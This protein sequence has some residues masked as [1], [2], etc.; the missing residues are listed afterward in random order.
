MQPYML[1]FLPALMEAESRP[2]PLTAPGVPVALSSCSSYADPVLA[3]VLD[4]VLQSLNLPSLFSVHVLLK[5]NLISAKHSPLACTE[6]AFLLAVARWFVDQGAKVS[7]G[8]SPAFG[9]AASVLRLLGIDKNL[10]RL[11]VATKEFRQGRSCPLPTGG[12]ALLAEDAL[13]ADLLVNLPRVKAHAQC[14]LTLAV[15]NFFGCVLGLRKAWWHML[16]GGPQGKFHQRLV[17]L[18]LLLPQSISLADG[19]VAMHQTGPINGT[20][21]P[22]AVVAAAHNPVALDRALHALLSLAP[23]RSPVMQA[24]I[25]AGMSGSCLATLSFPLAAPEALQVHDFKVPDALNPIRF[26]LVHFLQSSVRRLFLQSR[27]CKQ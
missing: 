4:R 15:K 23:E 7:L 18:P 22:L 6:G 5:P 21:Y 9:T 12:R 13:N 17:A 8:D 19:I 25:D 14:R 2:S 24:C 26:R 3:P 10:A 27:V 20:A 11:G 16:Y 1:L